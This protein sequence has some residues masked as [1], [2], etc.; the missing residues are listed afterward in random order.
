LKAFEE[1]ESYPG[2]SLIIAYS[3]CIE[4]GYELGQGWSSRNWR[5]TAASGRSTGLTRAASPLANPV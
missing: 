4:H 2:T 3:P 5:W 1:A